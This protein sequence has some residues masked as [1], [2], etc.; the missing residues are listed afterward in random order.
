[1][2]YFLHAFRR[3]SDGS[4]LCIATTWLSG[5]NGRIH[6]DRGSILTPGTTIEGVDVAAWLDDA[7]R[8]SRDLNAV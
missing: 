3:R 1:M 7:A 2:K 8:E 5:P 6:V 4:W